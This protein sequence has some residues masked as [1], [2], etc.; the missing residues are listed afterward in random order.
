MPEDSHWVRG[1]VEERSSRRWPSGERM[2]PTFQV[3]HVAQHLAFVGRLA[4]AYPDAVSCEL[5][6]DYLGL[7]DRVVS[8]PR[9]AVYFSLD[10]RSV[11]D[12]RRVRTAV[13]T[14]ALRADLAGT[15]A[16]LVGP[17]LRLF[18]GW[19]VDA[20]AVSSMLDRTR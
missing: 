11:V 16:A 18:D 6:V 10:R 3:Q 13:G 17:V 9:A 7:R 15:T 20:A 12:A 1:A 14:A 5:A 2:S 8:E 19:D 4:E